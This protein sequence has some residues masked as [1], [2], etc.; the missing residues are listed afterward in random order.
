MYLACSMNFSRLFC[1]TFS[2]NLN[3]LIRASLSSNILQS[4][5][6]FCFC[7]ETSPATSFV[8]CCSESF[9]ETLWLPAASCVSSLCS[10][11]LCLQFAVPAKSTASKRGHKTS[12]AHAQWSTLGHDLT[13]Q[14]SLLLKVVA[15]CDCHLCHN[16]FNHRALRLFVPFTSDLQMASKTVLSS[17]VFHDYRVL[18]GTKGSRCVRAPGDGTWG[19]KL[20]RLRLGESM[21]ITAGSQLRAGAALEI[22][23]FFFCFF[24]FLLISWFFFQREIEILMFLSAIVMMKN[25]RAS[26]YS[27]Q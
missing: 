17:V 19:R 14:L 10:I 22:F 12:L 21:E 2:N 7:E 26:E 1:I 16:G 6:G 23:L 25:R 11:F 24:C 20:L 8:C 9:P 5:P 3:L 15:A 18:G 27:K 4:D 13:S